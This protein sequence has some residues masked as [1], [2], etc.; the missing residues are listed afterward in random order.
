MSGS[1]KFEREFESFLKEDDSPLAALYRKLPRQEP[2]AKLDAAVLAMARRAAPAATRVRRPR[3]IPALSAAAVVM[4]AAGIAFRIGP[5]VWQ[6]RDT[7]ALQKTSNEN[8]VSAP[9]PAPTAG[10]SARPADTDAFKDQ[11]APKAAAAPEPESRAAPP[12]PAS[13]PAAGYAAA[14]KPAPRAIGNKAETAAKRSDAPVPQAFPMQAAPAEREK[15]ALESGAVAGAADAVQSQATGILDGRNGDR[16]RDENAKEAPEAQTLNLREESAPAPV[17]APVTTT[18][19]TAVPATAPAAPPPAAMREEPINRQAETA[20]EQEKQTMRGA[21]A[22]TLSAPA[23]AK[24]TRV[25][26][27][28]SKDPNAQLYPEHWLANIRTMLRENKRDAALRSLAEF[29]K[30]YPDYHLPDDL[31]DLK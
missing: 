16:K 15:K 1:E 5:T 2:D 22:E 6:E 24:A 13:A 11:V 19:T 8:A 4:L 7:R 31:R 28:R 30:M 27:L 12:P 20:T 21:P 17:T 9:A 18:S 10:E 23:A 26:P 14:A 29:R 3:W 25:V